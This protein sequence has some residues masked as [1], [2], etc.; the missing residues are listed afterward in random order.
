M[1]YGF[2]AVALSTG[3]LLLKASHRAAQRQEA[4]DQQQEAL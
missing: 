3:L 4:C 1:P 2:A